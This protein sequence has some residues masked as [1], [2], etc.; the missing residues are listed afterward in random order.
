M[1]S[2]AKAGTELGEKP[3]VSATGNDIDTKSTRKSLDIETAPGTEASP[4]TKDIPH[5]TTDPKAEGF[6]DT[7]HSPNTKAISGDDID[8]VESEHNEL[9]RTETKSSISPSDIGGNS[10][11]ETTPVTKVDDLDVDNPF[12]ELND[13]EL[14]VKVKEF[15]N[16]S[17]HLGKDLELLKS[18]AQL[19]KDKN[20][21]LQDSEKFPVSELS[22]EQ[23]D[24]L[25]TG[26]AKS[27]FWHQSKYL[28]GSV[29]SACL[30]GIIQ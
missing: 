10:I 6:L 12:K 11:S 24:Y 3:Q 7:K 15:T 20:N 14:G 29:L 13:T 25:L 1:A 18:G 26:E 2:T 4:D 17:R 8:E 28:K 16:T 30:A 9:G 27:D 22:Q 5:S 21:Y 23:R 19:A